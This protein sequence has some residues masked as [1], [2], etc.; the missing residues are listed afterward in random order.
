VEELTLNGL[1]ID[2]RNNSGGWI[3][4]SERLLQL[5]TPCHI[6][7]ERPQFINT[8]LTYDLCRRNAPFPHLDLTPWFKTFEQA[9]QTGAIYSQSFP[10]LLHGD[11]CNNIGQSYY[12]HVVLITDALCYSAT[13]M[14]AAGLQ[15]HKIGPIL[16]TNGNTGLEEQMCGNISFS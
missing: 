9:V 6:K 4:A 12:G 13:G 11:L 15:D 16:G 7:P 1:I 3:M 2:V 10:T 8:P 14:L 5:F